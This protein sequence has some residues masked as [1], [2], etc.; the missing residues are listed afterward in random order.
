[1]YMSAT[2][3]FNEIFI[4]E[5][6]RPSPQVISVTERFLYKLSYSYESDATRQELTN[7]TMPSAM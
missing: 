3:P 7:F 2:A 5:N 1:M 6:F 4:D